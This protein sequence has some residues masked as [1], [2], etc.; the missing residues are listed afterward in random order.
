MPQ[1]PAP[2]PRDNDY[3]ELRR[4]AWR[5]RQVVMVEAT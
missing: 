2:A 3:S 1:T 4:H 5:K